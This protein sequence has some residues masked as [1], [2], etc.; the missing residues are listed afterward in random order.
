MDFIILD[1]QPIEACNSI[2]VILKRSFLITSNALINYMNEVMKLSFGIMTL[3]MN[4]FNKS[5]L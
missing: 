3:E 1:T 2:P 5:N 4:V